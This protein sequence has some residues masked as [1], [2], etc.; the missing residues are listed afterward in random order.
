LD[1]VDHGVCV[2]ALC[3]KHLPLREG[4][5]SVN[6]RT[7]ASWSLLGRT[8]TVTWSLLLALIVMLSSRMMGS[9][10][11]RVVMPLLDSLV[12]VPLLDSLVGVPPLDSLVG[13]PLPHS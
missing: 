4:V 10:V 13:V 12:G 3:G 8:L 2:G 9:R 6:L 7:A 11:L 5:T 1:A